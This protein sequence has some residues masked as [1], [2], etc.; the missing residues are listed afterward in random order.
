MQNKTFQNKTN[1]SF[2]VGSK[3][4]DGV[5][6]ARGK[7][8]QRNTITCTAAPTDQEHLVDKNEIFNLAGSSI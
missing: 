1:I 8:R 5:A 7:E 3:C 4:D 6:Q 2:H